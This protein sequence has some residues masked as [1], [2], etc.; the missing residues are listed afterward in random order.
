M[1]LPHRRQ[2]ATPIQNAPIKASI[3]VSLLSAA[4]ARLWTT[5]KKGFGKVFG[6]AAAVVAALA[7]LIMM[8]T[9]GRIIA[10]SRRETAV[11]RAIGA[12]RLDIA[13]IYLTYVIL[14]AALVFAVSL[15]LAL[16]LSSYLNHRYSESV[17]IDALLA[18]NVSDLTQKITLLH[19]YAKDLL[20]V[21]ALIM[22]GALAAAL[23]PILNNVRR[24]PIRDMRDER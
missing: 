24:N 14:L 9:V 23:F 16:I 6:I 22:G 13:E 8:G 15:I 10:D 1:V 2:V 17:T 3:L 11:F 7:A 20:Y 4:A 12:K 18:F 5:S 21:L 19:V